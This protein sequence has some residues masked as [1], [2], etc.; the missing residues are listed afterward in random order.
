MSTSTQR[1]ALITGANGGFGTPLMVDLLE[2]GWRVSAVIRG[3]PARLPL[4]PEVQ[5]ALL[6]G[7][8]LVLDLDLTALVESGDARPLVEGRLDALVNIAGT[9]V[10]GSVSDVPLGTFRELLQLNVEAPYLLTQAHLPQLARSRGVVVQVSSLSARQTLPY[11][12]VYAATKAALETLSEALHQEVAELGVRVHC[13]QPG[14]YRTGVQ[15]RMRFV[16][17]DRLPGL[18]EGFGKFRAFVR[19][20][21]IG[22]AGDPEEVSALIVSLLSTRTGR[23]RHAIGPGARLS[24]WLSWIPERLRLPVVRWGLWAR[25]RG[26]VPLTSR[27]SGERS[28]EAVRIQS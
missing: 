8:L 24:T 18:H 26:V 11:Y 13:I 17:P 1:H 20:A 25:V 2:R 21:G 5:R 27:L 19:T 4:H 15:H 23:F 6:E 12:G 28:E 9:S 7:R 16:A 14:A 3:G 10:F 22:M